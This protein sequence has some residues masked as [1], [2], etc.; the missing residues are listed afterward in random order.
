VNIIEGK[1]NTDD[2]NCDEE[3]EG[4]YHDIKE[5]QGLSTRQKGDISY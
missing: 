3:K 2:T 4:R 5:G 1:Y